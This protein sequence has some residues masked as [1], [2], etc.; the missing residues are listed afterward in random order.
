MGFDV[1]LAQA[2]ARAMRVQLDIKVM[3]FGDLMTALAELLNL[4]TMASQRGQAWEGRIILY[5]GGNSNADA[6]LSKD[7]T[8]RRYMP[9]GTWHYQRTCPTC[10]GEGR[11]SPGAAAAAI[12]A[13]D[14]ELEGFLH[15]RIHR[16]TINTEVGTSVDPDR[17]VDAFT[18]AIDAAKEGP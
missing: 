7:G 14:P 4:I 6:W 3:P 1:D 18:R 17:L 13:A 8:P 9:Q 11:C 10:G 12:L 2:L 16:I 15:P 5:V